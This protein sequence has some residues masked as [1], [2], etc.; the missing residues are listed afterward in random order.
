MQRQ[1]ELPKRLDEITGR[2]DA[3]EQQK[4]DK[5]LKKIKKRLHRATAKLAHQNVLL[6]AVLGVLTLVIAIVAGF[7]SFYNFKLNE[8]SKEYGKF[9]AAR[10]QFNSLLLHQLQRDMREVADRLFAVVDS[11][12]LKDRVIRLNKQRHDLQDLGI[13]GDQFKETS[14]LIGALHAA[15][16]ENKPEEAKS[17]LSLL[18]GSRD[19]RIQSRAIATSAMIVISPDRGAVRN[20]LKEE[21]EKAVKMDGTNA[22]A[23]T[24]LGILS[25]NEAVFKLQQLKARGVVDLKDL[26]AAADLLKE[27]NIAFQI[28]GGLDPSKYGAY[29]CSN[30]RICN[31]LY[32]VKTYLAFDQPDSEIVK[33]VGYDQ[34][35]TFFQASFNELIAYSSL[36]PDLPLVL[37]TAAQLRCVQAQY[38][39]HLKN[40]SEKDIDALLAEAA[41]KFKQA[42][43]RGLYKKVESPE[44]AKDN[45]EKDY[46]NEEIVNH[47][48][49]KKAVE[50]EIENYVGKK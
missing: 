5:K 41:D 10:Q 15:I 40:K 33:H 22:L 21:V 6:K 7:G 37:E 13:D 43:A 47:P 12:E 32:L 35:D 20:T 18:K 50:D 25:S 8:Q 39:R 46:L 42:I 28:A 44:K 38:A 36:V 16:V 11:E 31:N 45:F 9:E 48:Q 23:L 3:I 17:T 49:Y 26:Q 2:L 4:D 14:D 30:N 29:R 1:S 34:L 24:C 27:A 19:E